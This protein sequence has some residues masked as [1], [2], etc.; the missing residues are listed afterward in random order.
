MAGDPATNT[1]STLE[2]FS[3]GNFR[4][5]R[6]LRS[7]SRAFILA[8]RTNNSFMSSAL[9][10]RNGRIFRAQ[11][12]PDGIWWGKMDPLPP[13]PAGR[14]PKGLQPL[15][16]HSRFSCFHK[17]KPKNTQKNPNQT[18]DGNKLSAITR[19]K[20]INSSRCNKSWRSHPKIPQIFQKSPARAECRHRYSTKEQAE[21]PGQGEKRKVWKYSNF[22][23]SNSSGK[24]VFPTDS[25]D[26]K[27]W[28]LA[29]PPGLSKAIN[30]KQWFSSFQLWSCA[31][32]IPF[33]NSQLIFEAVCTN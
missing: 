32:Q 12:L 8:W 5:P 23:S 3:R 28:H 25:C 14:I 27:W 17:K 29:W 31:N 1:S 33:L 24:T 6:D 15:L 2:L 11:T 30:S 19:W 4:I 21:N 22:Y 20:W 7:A 13:C 10:L 16:L 18:E 26:I 9:T